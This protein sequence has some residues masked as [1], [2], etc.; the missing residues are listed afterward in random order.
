MISYTL[1]ETAFLLEVSSVKCTSDKYIGLYTTS[2][3]NQIICI[4]L[5]NNN[6]ED[7]MNDTTVSGVL[8]N[9]GGMLMSYHNYQTILDNVT[10]ELDGISREAYEW[11]R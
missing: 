11:V 9:N 3:V 5:G 4:Q 7:N 8:I 1:L 2:I 6:R 10:L